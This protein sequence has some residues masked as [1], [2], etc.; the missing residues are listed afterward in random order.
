M[1][2][3]RL[4]VEELRAIDR[5]ELDMR[6]ATGQ[7]RRRT[8]LLGVNGAG[9]TTTLDA[10]VHALSELANDDH[11]GATKLGAPSMSPTF[12]RVRAGFRLESIA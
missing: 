10:I 5:L 9:K 11:I 7:P 1:H 3:T 6:N 2:I 12:C 8:I 4:V